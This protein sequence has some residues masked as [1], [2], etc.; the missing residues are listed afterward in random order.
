MSNL[1]K[2]ALD[3]DSV[4]SDTMVTWTEKFNFERG[5]NL[6]KKDITIWKFWENIDVVKEEDA[7]YFFRQAWEDWSN[8]PPT[9]DKLDEKVSKIAE[10]G[11]IDVVTRVD[12]THLRYVDKWL[13]H[14]NI[15]DIN[16]VKHAGDEKISL[17]YD[18]FIDD[19][20]DLA[21]AAKEKNKKCFVYYQEW[22]KTV[23]E[24]D[25]V[26]KIKDLNH[27]IDEISKKGI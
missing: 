1:K 6:S 16:E 5:E 17:N 8:L 2:I 21:K 20:P 10:F 12:D 15:D 14:N 19:D 7:G 22:N 26:T 3:F 27:A 13:H 18:L 25:N 24:S 9:E 4:L 11:K 23:E